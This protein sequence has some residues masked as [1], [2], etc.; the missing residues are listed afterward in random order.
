MTA[1]DWETEIVS[2]LD[3]LSQVQD[4]LF[5]VLGEKRVCM[6]HRDREGM[7]ALDMREQEVRERLEACHDRR[8]QLLR[9]ARQ[10]SLPHE[11]L[12]KL[13]A[14]GVVGGR[15]K[16][17]KRVN[18]TAARMR[19]LQ[20][21]SLTNWVAAQR[22]LLHFAQMLEI[23]ATGGRPDPTYRERGA[24]CAAGGSLVDQEA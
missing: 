4:A 18:H 17:T 20:H 2:L 3:E 14:S 21:E 15:E 10:R 22:S 7:A 23:L 5:A 8:Q 16:L 6:A 13:A 19:L 1:I 12:G 24:A 9:A 11:S